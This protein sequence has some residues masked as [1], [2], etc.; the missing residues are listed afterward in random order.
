MSNTAAILIAFACYLIMMIT[1]GFIFMKRTKSTADYFLGGRG[2]NSWVAALSAQASDMSGWLLMGLPG[3]IYLAGTGK[4][5]IAIGLFIGTVLNWL[6]ISKRLRRYTIVANNSL[7]LPE[8]FQ[9]RFRDKKKILLGISSVVIVIFFLVYTASALASGG[10]L[11]NTVF[12]IDYH[13]AMLIGAAVI[14]AYTFMGG[15]L[16][17]CTTDFIQGTLMLVALLTV[18]IIA[19]GTISGDMTGALAAKGVAADSDFLSLFYINGEPYSFV[20]IISDLAWG[21]GYCGMPHI[22]VRFMAVRSEKEL[23][24]SS[25]IAIIWVAISLTAACV[26]GVVGRGYLNEILVDG[27]SENIFIKMIQQIFSGNMIL[28]FIGGLFLCGILAAIMS[29]A[30]SQLLVCASS[31]SKD[32]FKNILRP[33][34]AD[35][36]VLNVSRITVIV[37]AV[38]ACL[39]AWDPNS[40]IMALV[41]DAWAGL[42]S[43]F[44]PLVVCALFWKRTNLPGAVAG[45]VSG[46]LFVIIWDY[47]PIVNGETPYA[48][49]GI[50]SLLLGFFI[51]LI[52]IVVV[53][54]VTKAPAQEIVE[55]FDKVNSYKEAE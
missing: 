45:I 48:A 33:D 19:Y 53:S 38:L 5:W 46:G 14:L 41:S 49:T 31:A 4:A 3:S 40:S 37:V 6:L 23:K 47:L 39:I 52:C 50:Y 51:S 11:F 43:A 7:T 34:A 20:S 13:T 12:N 21:L 2:L 17:V 44:G 8:F 1:V 32:I 22:L 55:E 24:K 10:K 36:K 54:L 25:V 26:I 18:P 27:D 29:T 42:G 30:D 15:F 35:K 16:A 9:N 28:V